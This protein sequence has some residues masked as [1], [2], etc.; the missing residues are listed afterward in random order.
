MPAFYPTTTERL[1]LRP[2][3]AADSPNL[4]ARRSDP[5]VAQYQNWVTPYPLEAAQTMLAELETMDGPEDQEWYMVGVELDGTLIGD[6]AVHLSFGARS[7]EIGYTFDTAF[8]GHGY[9]SEATE[10]LVGYLFEDV[11]VSRVSAMLHPENLASAMLL[12][13]LGFDFEGHT[14]LSFWIGDENSDDWIYGLTREQWQAWHDRP[15]TEPV[16]VALVGLHHDNYR[17]FVDITMHKS[18][19]RF[20]APVSRSIAAASFPPSENGYLVVPWMRGVEADGEVVGFVMLSMRSQGHDE[21]YLWRLNIDRLHQRRGIGRRVLDALVAQ[22]QARSDPSLLV[23]WMPGRGSPEQFYLD[24]G[25]V[26]TGEMEGDE[27]AARLD[28]SISAG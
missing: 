27:I 28:L 19:E 25:F 1:L 24:Y 11:G 14:K 7:A 20:V 6:L 17:S 10:A 5:Q 12:E 21:P 23:S 16:H 3:V 15:R 4:S 22:C 18:Q 9:A 13:R 26:P 2:M 8:W